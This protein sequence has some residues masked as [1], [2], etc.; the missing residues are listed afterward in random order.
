VVLFSKFLPQRQ[1]GFFTSS[2]PSQIGD[3]LDRSEMGF[4]VPMAVQTPSHRLILGLMND[5]HLV[6]ATMACYARNS[7]IYVS[8]VIEVDIIGQSMDPH[9]V[10]RLTCPP[11]VSN[12][13]ELWRFRVNCRPLRGSSHGF[14]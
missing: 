7:T 9:P 14:G 11:A 12:G 10:D 6:D 8:G 3:F 4:W 1:L 13:L 5:L 2:G